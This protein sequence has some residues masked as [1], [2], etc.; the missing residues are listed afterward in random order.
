MSRKLGGKRTPLSGSRS[1]HTS[2]DVIFPKGDNRYC[3]VKSRKK[4]AIF[5]LW[6]DVAEKAKKEK[7]K[8]ML[9]L[10]EVGT[11]LYLRVEKFEEK[12]ESTTP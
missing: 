9:V 10:H 5:T 4:W 7:K 2:G 3:E 8:P 1:G 11:K 6:R 12:S